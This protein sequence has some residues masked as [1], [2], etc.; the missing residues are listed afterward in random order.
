MNKTKTSKSEKT[1]TIILVGGETAGPVMPLLAL[2]DY[3]FSL[4]SNIEPIFLDKKKSV[5][6]RLVPSKNYK[7]K[8]IYSGKLRRYF[9]IKNFFSPL[10]TIIGLIQSL[11]LLAANRPIIVIGAGG[12]VQVPVIIAAW[13]LRI[14]RI[15]HQQD[16]VP[17]FSNKICNPF[18]NKITT[19]FEKSVKDFPQGFGLGKNYSQYN[20]V[21]WTGNPTDIAKSKIS[22]QDKSTAQ[23]LFKLE[24]DWPTVLVIG[25]G[26]GAR[27]LNA[28]VAH[29]LPELLKIGQVVHSTGPGKQI[30]PDVDIAHGHDRYHQFEFINHITEAYIAADIVISRA[31]IGTITALSALGKLSI[32]VPMPDTHQEWNA[33]YLY[34]HN[35]A[36]V[37]DERDI[38]P[39]TLAKAVRKILFDADLQKSLQANIRAIMPGNATEKM[40]EVIKQVIHE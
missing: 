35:A 15:I 10:L 3:W 8:S 28:A 22:E 13:I 16:I 5:A 11:F 34:D 26:S 33:K 32:I 4:D 7:F 9:S 17:T 20:K 14:P 6:A 40:L 24:E 37:L 2:A 1:K 30:K 29:N 38:T 31:G 18:V 39:E 12:Y 36:L 19:T 23:H 21:V 27:G 25:G